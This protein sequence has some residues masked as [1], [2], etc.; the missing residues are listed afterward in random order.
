MSADLASSTS[1]VGT[2]LPLL[3]L[4]LLSLLKAMMFVCSSPRSF[5]GLSLLR[6]ARWMVAVVPRSFVIIEAR[7]S[8]KSNAVPPWRRE[9]GGVGEKACAISMQLLFNVIITTMRMMMSIIIGLF[10][11]Y[12][13]QVVWYIRMVV[14]E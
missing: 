5:V 9:G 11:G 6:L 12:S 7:S 4:L 13:R 14:V 10:G 2:I 3:L 8:A 1:A